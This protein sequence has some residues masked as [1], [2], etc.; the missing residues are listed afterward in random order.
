MQQLDISLDSIGYIYS[1]QLLD[2]NSQQSTFNLESVVRIKFV[3]GVLL[4]N[5]YI[6][7]HYYD[8]LA[9]DPNESSGTAYE[10]KKK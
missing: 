1:R 4:T 3:F 6:K 10:Q 2:F 9:H 5:L 7:C 8:I